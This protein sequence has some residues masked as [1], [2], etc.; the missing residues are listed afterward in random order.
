MAHQHN[1]YLNL[2]ILKCALCKMFYREL[3]GF[4]AYAPPPKKK[5]ATW[6]ENVKI[7]KNIGKPVYG[8]WELF[9]EGLK[10]NFHGGGVKPPCI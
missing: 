3:K 2:I 10:H 9:L 8:G 1:S 5:R 7:M 6:V 4:M